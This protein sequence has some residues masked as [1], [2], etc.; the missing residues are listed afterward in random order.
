MCVYLLFFFASRRRHTRCALV[1]GVQTC[2]LPIWPHVS[3][4]ILVQ[5]IL[6]AGER[7]TI[8]A[9]LPAGEFRL[10]TLEP[11]GEAIH[12]HDG[13]P[14]PT[15]IATA[16]ETPGFSIG[17]GNAGAAGTITFDKPSGRLLTFVNETRALRR[18]LGR[19]G[20]RGRVVKYGEIA[21]GA[22]S[23]KK[24]R[25]WRTVKSIQHSKKK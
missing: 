12:R 15:I 23:I 1:T 24:K 20:G 10:R 17:T 14:F 22:V 18:Q 13:G 16:I 2:A 19:A 5:Q 9:K 8:N 21:G 4:H 6:A 7:R 11:G 3:R 25:V